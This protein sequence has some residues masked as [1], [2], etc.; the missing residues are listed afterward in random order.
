MCSTCGCKGAE[1]F[2]AES[3]NFELIPSVEIEGVGIVSEGSPYLKN[4]D[5][6]WDEYNIYD[7]DAAEEILSIP[8]NDPSMPLQEGELKLIEAMVYGFDHPLADASWGE[9]NEKEMFWATKTME[10]L[11]N[12]EPYGAETFEAKAVFDVISIE[13]QYENDDDTDYWPYTMTVSVEH[14]ENKHFSFTEDA[15]RA[16]LESY[17]SLQQGEPVK[18]V[19][20]TAFYT[21]TKDPLRG[22][23]EDYEAE[24]FEAKGLFCP[25][26]KMNTR[27]DEDEDWCSPCEEQMWDAE[28]R[29]LNYVDGHAITIQ[30]TD[31]EATIDNAKEIIDNLVDKHGFDEDY[32]VGEGDKEITIYFED[33][34]GNTLRTL[35]YNV[36]GNKA[37]DAIIEWFF[38]YDYPIGG[39]TADAETFDVEFNEWADQEMLTHG[40]DISFK[41]WAEDEGLKHGDVPIT[42]WAEHEEESHDARYGADEIYDKPEVKEADRYWDEPTDSFRETFGPNVE[43]REFPNS[44]SVY[45]NGKV[46]KKYRGDGHMIKSRSWAEGL[47]DNNFSAESNSNNKLIFGALL[48]GL[49]VPTLSAFLN[50]KKEK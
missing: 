10:T 47:R 29:V 18:V 17:I 40:K 33:I 23:Y 22:N 32:E 28:H 4:W 15:I 2:G 34:G 46:V 11:A 12:Y 9:L 50:S 37:N 19:D 5:G 30:M 31:D 49:L 36:K 8:A 21:G 26:C 14:D 24:T 41:D 38:D 20:L 16:E 39:Y 25:S 3:V 42:D 35:N 7:D 27:M 13:Y 45:Q 1:N 48:V 44:S 43:V 6:E